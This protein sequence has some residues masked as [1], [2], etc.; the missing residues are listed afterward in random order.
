MSKEI[1]AYIESATGDARTV[2]E[3][4]PLPVTMLP[5][6]SDITP[7]DATGAGGTKTVASA[8]TPEALGSGTAREVHLFDL[9]SNTGT[10]KWGFTSANGT[11]HGTVPFV[12]RHPDGKLINL[13]D[14]YIDVENNG[15]GVAYHTLN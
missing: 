7:A 15:E 11:Q 12:I 5:P 10:P 8:G 3:T 14:I 13:A 9:E 4:H 6:S 2:D 1:V